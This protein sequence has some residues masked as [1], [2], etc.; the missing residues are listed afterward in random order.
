MKVGDLVKIIDS[1]RDDMRCT[2]TVLKFDIYAGGRH[3]RR[4]PEPIIEVLWNTA[5]I[6][7][8]LKSRVEVT[9]A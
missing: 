1:E 4:P 3:G 7:W 8:I 9:S 6:G 2:G 5:M